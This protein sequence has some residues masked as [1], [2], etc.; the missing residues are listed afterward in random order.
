M[1][2]LGYEPVYRHCN[3]ILN[4]SIGIEVSVLLLKGMWLKEVTI[5]VY[6]R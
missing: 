4:H 1:S 5:Y 2:R 6:I 3:L